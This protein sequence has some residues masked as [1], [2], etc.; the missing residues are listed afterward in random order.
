MNSQKIK[1]IISDDH[2]VCRDGLI[3][4]L[5]EEKYEIIGQAN[6]GFTLI[7]IVKQK[8]PDIVFI[9]IQMPIIDGIEATKEIHKICPSIKVIALT[10]FEQESSII[11]MFSAGANAYLLKSADKK[12]IIE[13][14]DSVLNNELYFSKEISKK[15]IYKVKTIFKENR[16]VKN[17][18]NLTDTEI[19]IIQLICDEFTSEE[20]GKFLFLSKRTIDGARLRIQNKIDVLSTAGIVK[21]AIENGIYRGIK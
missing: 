9:D 21:F 15:T 4:I 16:K 13:S 8:K 17:I 5:K 7:E 14:I 20:I 12:E 11:N 2:F 6:N 10:M 18:A 19:Q 3:S 1:I